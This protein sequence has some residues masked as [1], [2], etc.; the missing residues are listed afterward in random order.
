MD[1]IV[2]L[3]FLGADIQGIGRVL[4]AIRPYHIFLFALVIITDVD[5]LLDELIKILKGLECG[6]AL[7]L[8]NFDLV[9]QVVV[10]VLDVL[11][12]VIFV[13]LKAHLRFN[14]FYNFQNN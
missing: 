1:R 9:L 12:R 11:Y 8:E 2:D 13:K 6:L 3:D 4:E 7:I 10:N 5:G 14:I